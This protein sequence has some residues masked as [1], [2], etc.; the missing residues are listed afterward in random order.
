MSTENPD[1]TVPR[2]DIEQSYEK[3]LRTLKRGLRPRHPWGPKE[4]LFLAESLKEALTSQNEKLIEQILCLLQ[5]TERTPEIFEDLLCRLLALSWPSSRIKI[6][7]LD[8]STKYIIQRRRKL[9][10][11]LPP[12]YLKTVGLLLENPNPELKEWA[13]R[14]IDEMGK[15]GRPLASHILKNR[16]R[17]WQMG[18]KHHR[19]CHDIIEM[20]MTKWGPHERVG[21]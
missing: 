18:N 16:P 13:L 5:G 19:H 20:L 6:F 15:E 2:M 3:A 7:A 8:T 4:F 12:L 9:S 17:F 10:L 21:K 14:V 1:G 11:P